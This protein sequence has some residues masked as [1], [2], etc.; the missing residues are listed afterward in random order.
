VAFRHWLAGL[1]VFGENAS[2]WLVSSMKLVQITYKKIDSIRR[3]HIVIKKGGGLPSIR[4]TKN[5]QLNIYLIKDDYFSGR[6]L[7][8]VKMRC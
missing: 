7:A 6:K 1:I 2:I 5:I 8:I 4:I 3:N